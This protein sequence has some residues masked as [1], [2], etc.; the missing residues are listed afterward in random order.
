MKANQSLIIISL[1]GI[2]T[3]CSSI[4]Q[5]RIYTFR[6]A[7]NA[8]NSKVKVYD[9]I[10]NL[11]AKVKVKRSKKDLPIQLIT[12][13]LIKDYIIKSSVSP[14]FAYGNLVWVGAAPYAYI[15]DLTNQKRFYYGK[16]AF[17]DVKD[18]VSVIRTPLAK[19]YYHYFSRDFPTNKGQIYLKLSIPFING[20][21]YQPE[22]EGIRRDVGFWGFSCGLEYYYKEN[23]YL[24]LTGN[25]VTGFFVPMGAVDIKGE[26]EQMSTLYLSLTDNYKIKRY[27]LGY[28]LNYSVNY[29]ELKYGYAFQDTVVQTR[30]PLRKINQ[31]IGI[32]LSGYF[33]FG[34]VFYLGL[35]YR[36][37]FLNT[38]PVVEFKYQH[39]ISVDFMWK[40]KLK[41]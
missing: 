27:H 11:P 33:Q 6:I 2:L 34:K 20:Y 32:T 41:K 19:H 15:I 14:Q 9:S 16:S 26:Y 21:F 40:L 12:D 35:I 22:G 25:A 5:R 29:W 4:T 30:A 28:G 37:T 13:T 17:L 18:T 8:S 24:S 3:A 36:P 38:A 1:V 7:S 10:Y 23:K 39:L 31:S